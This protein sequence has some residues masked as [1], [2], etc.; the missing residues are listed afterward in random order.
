MKLV[1][2]LYSSEFYKNYFDK[3]T[4]FSLRP[5]TAQ[6]NEISGKCETGKQNSG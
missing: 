1:R 3:F 4:Y 6:I 2:P 5:V